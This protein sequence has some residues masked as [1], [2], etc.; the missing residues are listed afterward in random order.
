MTEASSL[1][2]RARDTGVAIAVAMGVMNVST[3]GFQMIAA[4]ALGP[5]E[6]GAFAALM[7]V[8]MIVGVLALGLQATAARRISSH[9]EGVGEIERAIL[10]VTYRSA[11]MVG[12]LLLVLSPVI[13]LVLRLDSIVSAA[14]IGLAAVPLTIM[15]GQ[16]GVL[17]GERRWLALAMVYVAAGVPRLV[18]GAAIVLWQPSELSA[19]VAVAVTAL[20][21]VLAGSIALRGTRLPRSPAPAP[22]GPSL[23]GEVARNSQA[24]LAFFALGNVDVMVARNVL[25]GHDAGLYAAG[26][27]MTKAVLFL[28]QFVVVVSFPAM[29]SVHE[30]RRT[31]LRGLATV[32]GIGVAATAAA[33]LLP[34]L[35]MIFVGGSEY[36]EIE[37]RLWLF[38][39]LG[40]LLA[41]LQLLV[42]A[43]VA[44]QG[45]RSVYLPWAGV[46]LVVGIGVLCRT[47]DTLLAVVVAV[48]ALLLAVL[49]T[50]S[51]YLAR[52]PVPAEDPTVMSE[53]V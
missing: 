30:R 32:A 27:I 21:P 6:Y 44:G 42:Y 50:V 49:V 12:A 19:M 31:L 36:A 4:R 45:R 1:R 43:V 9:P 51:L 48:D 38:A 23:L 22:P 16:A 15:G 3:Y 29:S 35:A 13:A 41:M 34:G 8:T 25:D 26:L 46:A 7:N 10:R 11:A 39:V 18:V 52:S 40:T 2:P 37:S 28:P 33:F 17:Q 20:A 53:G 5:R 47:P 24:L 14:V